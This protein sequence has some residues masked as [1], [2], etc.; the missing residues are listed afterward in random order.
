MD[1]KGNDGDD[2]VVFQE[3]VRNNEWVPYD[4]P[5]REENE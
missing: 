4:I 3:P 5:R 1:D 2:Y